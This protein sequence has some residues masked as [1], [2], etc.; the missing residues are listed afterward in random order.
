MPSRTFTIWALAMVA[1]ALPARTAAQ[2]DTANATTKEAFNFLSG[3]AEIGSFVIFPHEATQQ[4]LERYGL[5]RVN[6]TPPQFG[7]GGNW[8]NRDALGYIEV[9]VGSPDLLSKEFDTMWVVFRPAVEESM[10]S[11]MLSHLLSTA[12]ETKIDGADTVRIQFQ[13]KRPVP[14][15]KCSSRTELTVRM[16][17]GALV[18]HLLTTMCEAKR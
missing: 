8:A 9:H 1:L 5:L 17:T 6:E 16:T 2:S 14:L 10:P 13:F 7:W 18:S 3:Q 11:A 15:S 12:E 4:L